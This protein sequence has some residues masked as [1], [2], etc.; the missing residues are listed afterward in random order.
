MRYY[1][2]KRNNVNKQTFNVRILERKGQRLRLFSREFL[3]KLSV[4]DHSRENAGNDDIKNRAYN[5][6]ANYTDWQISLRIFGLLHYCRDGIKTNICEEDNRCSRGNPSPAIGHKRPPV[7][8]LQILRANDY[9]EGQ[10]RQFY[11]HHY[12]VKPCALTD[13]NQQDN[14][15]SRY[16]Q[17]S[18][19]VKN[20][21]NAKYVRGIFYQ[22]WDLMGGLEIGRKPIRNYITD[23]PEEGLEI[24]CP[25]YGNSNIANRIF[26]NQIPADNP[27]YKLSQGRV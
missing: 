10:D 19:E 13:S 2:A 11:K 14:G 3:D 25:A 15:N 24:V 4:R 20:N 22:A 5:E 18:N 23:S 8:N 1:R 7:I 17:E 16:N 9:E 27:G 12:S 6:R 26:Y 21:G